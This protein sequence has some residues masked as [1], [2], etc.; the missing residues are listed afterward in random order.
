MISVLP[1]VTQFMIC[2]ECNA[3][4]L[5]E[6]LHAVHYCEHAKNLKPAAYF[7]LLLAS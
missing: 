1:E 7:K 2:A 3:Q 5:H 4:I 6:I